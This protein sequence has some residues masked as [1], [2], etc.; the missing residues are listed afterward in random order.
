MTEYL[1]TKEVAAYLRINEKRIYTLVNEGKLPATRVGGKW[2]YPKDLLDEWLKK[3]TQIPPGGLVYSLLDQMLL[4][5][6]SDDPVLQR[7]IQL[8]QSR[9]KFPV[10]SARVGSS[11][12]LAALEQGVVHIASCHLEQ[13]QIEKQLA[14]MDGYCLIHLFERQQGL[15]FDSKK[16]GKQ[17]VLKKLMKSGVGFAMRQAGSGTHK[18]TLSLLQQLGL[19]ED[20]IKTVGPF[21]THDEVARAILAGRAD[22]G[23]GIQCAAEQTGLDFIPYTTESFRLAIPLAV[24]SH[25][26]TARFLDFLFTQ[27]PG[28]LNVQYPG[29]NFDNLGQIKTIRSQGST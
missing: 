16:L 11:Q 14:A 26:N 29:Y 9:T 7:S 28:K 18:L 2:L 1:T 17:S 3:S 10:L 4:I 24:V 12:G 23:L 19:G 15:L 5:Q 6:G 25:E 22:T 27:I 13:G 20:D 8:F 21:Y